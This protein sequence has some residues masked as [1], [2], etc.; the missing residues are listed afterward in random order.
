MNMYPQPFVQKGKDPA[1]LY[2][3]DYMSKRSGSDKECYTM[4][5]PQE[6]FL[7]RLAS[8]GYY[9][10]NPLGEEHVFEKKTGN[11]SWIDDY[12]QY[13]I[14]HAAWQEA[15]SRK[16]SVEQMVVVILIKK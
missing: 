6:S 12:K 10:D 16:L 13:E 2:W 7:S 15:E 4:D 5:T 3:R 1:D 8:W 11:A 14:H 9:W